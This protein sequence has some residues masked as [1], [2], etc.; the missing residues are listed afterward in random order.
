ML[1]LY[2]LESLDGELLKGDYNAR[3]LREFIP[4][5]GTELMIEQKDFEARQE[6]REEMVDM[7]ENEVVGEDKVVGDEKETRVEKEVE[8]MRSAGDR[9]VA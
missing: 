5:E 6:G 9:D 4:R 7:G 8:I 1:N 2:M 3:R